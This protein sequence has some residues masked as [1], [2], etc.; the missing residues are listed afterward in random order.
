M[1]SSNDSVPKI[2]QSI[3]KIL[4]K[5]N[6]HF[7]YPMDD[8]KLGLISEDWINALFIFSDE[9]IQHAYDQIIQSCK[10]RP[11]L[12]EFITQCNSSRKVVSAKN[13]GFVAQKYVA[14]TWDSYKAWVASKYGNA[15][16]VKHLLPAKAEYDAAKANGTFEEYKKTKLKE[17]AALLRSKKLA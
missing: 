13:A 2:K 15:T 4:F 11:T 12:A 5:I 10:K 3:V 17:L 14:E 7:D 6:S 1:P 16:V 8:K 9:V